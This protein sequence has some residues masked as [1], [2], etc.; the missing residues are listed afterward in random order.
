MKVPSENQL[1]VT[2]ETLCGVVTPVIAAGGG[3]V[4][5][6]EPVVDVGAVTEDPPHPASSPATAA[7]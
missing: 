1:A 5:P 4:L 3:L 2:T 6:V 7:V